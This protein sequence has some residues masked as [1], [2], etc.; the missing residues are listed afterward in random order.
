MHTLS[1]IGT[2]GLS[3][4]AIKAY[5]SDCSL[6]RTG[7]I[8]FRNVLLLIHF[9]VI[10]FSGDTYCPPGMKSAVSQSVVSARKIVSELRSH[11]HNR[12]GPQLNLHSRKTNYIFSH[13]QTV[14]MRKYSGFWY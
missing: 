13:T 7:L 4:Q 6:I 10:A 8:Y 12:T 3:V 11:T 9:H 1:R 14:L 5:A 2:H